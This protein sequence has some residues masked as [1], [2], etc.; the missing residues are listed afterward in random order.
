[1]TPFLRDEEAMKGR[2]VD[3]WMVSGDGVVIERLWTDIRCSVLFWSCV[4]LAANKR[5]MSLV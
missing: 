5:F 2:W 3:R 1:M 4:K